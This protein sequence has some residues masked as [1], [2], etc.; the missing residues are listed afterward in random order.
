[1]DVEQLRDDASA[2]KITVDKLIDVIALQQEQIK[3]L[4]AIIQSKNPTE[5]LEEPYSEKAEL[6]RKG[7]AGKRK[8]K[9]LRRGRISTADKI[10]LAQRTEIVLP[11]GMEI[12]HCKLSHTR[13]AWRLENGRAVL[14]AYQ[15]FRHGNRFGKPAGLLGRSEF[16]IEI[17]VAVAYQVYCLGLSIDKACA[18]LSFFQQ[19]KLRKS[20]A[21]ALLNQ[22]ARAWEAEFD[23]LC[24]LL[25]HSAVVH[26]D[27][28]SW[29]INSVWAF[30]SDKLTV[31]FYGV[32][33]DGDTL[34]QILDKEAFAGVLVS[35][36]AAVYQGFTKAQKCWAHLI[37]KA[38]KLTLQDPDNETYRSFADRLL[39]IY[40]TAK[41]IK[42]DGRLIDSTR[43]V[44]VAGLDD[45]LLELCGQRWV[46]DDTSGSE[47]E[48]DY[49]RLCHEIMRL[50]LRQELFVFVT[51]QAADGNNNAAERQ[52][53]DDALARK[54]CRTSKTPAGAKRR[55]VIS[56]VLQSISKQLEQF[57]L[58]SVIAEATKWL[59]DGISSFVRQVE[60]HGL[61]PPGC[62]SKGEEKSLLDRLVLAAD[63]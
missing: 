41:R 57:T 45:E 23:S 7:K 26:T 18:V 49:R 39:E 10:K 36:D 6:K 38:I 35:D 37:R 9:P 50:M 34:S 13:V 32:H 11:E 30:L 51:E 21:D 60:S 46:D 42:A 55:S 59:D 15:I 40:N 29:S 1:M 58:E 44:R 48:N 62:G 27:E 3:R 12:D 16:G 28:T 63:H 19:L 5:R 22:L 33:K 61:D 47:I 54:T 4:E 14:V 25:A 52:L 20:Q 53:R 56:S 2:G 31:L 8:R 17:I 24:T 43:L